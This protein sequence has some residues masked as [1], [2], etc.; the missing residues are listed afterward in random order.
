[1][2]HLNDIEC[3]M[4]GDACGATSAVMAQGCTSSSV[5]KVAAACGTLEFGKIMKQ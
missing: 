2:R 4:L 1:M 5:N 3:A